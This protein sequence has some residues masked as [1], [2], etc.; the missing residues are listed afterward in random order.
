M[1][2]FI[3][4]DPEV[5]LKA[6]EGHDNVLAP[7]NTSMEAFY[8]QFV[9]PQCGGR[10]EKSFIS[11]QHAFGGETLIARYGLRCVLCD[12]LF[13]PHSNSLIVELGSPGKLVERV[14]AGGTP[15]VGN[16]PR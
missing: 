16:R 14:M 4:M 10:C 2:S 9:C 3:E 6:I 7:E 13:D 1:P 5:A 15:I 12:C 11:P 8:R